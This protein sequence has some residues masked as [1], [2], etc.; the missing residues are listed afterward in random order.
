M[1]KK[2]NADVIA[3]LGCKKRVAPTIWKILGPKIDRYFEPFCGSAAIWLHRPEENKVGI[4]WLGDLD[5]LLVNA[6]RAIQHE[7][8]WLYENH[9]QIFDDFARLGCL[10]RLKD[11]DL[12]LLRQNLEEDQRWCDR[13]LALDFLQV[14]NT[15]MSA[16]INSSLN[17]N[18]YKTYSDR[19][20]ILRAG[21]KLDSVTVRVFCRDWE[22]LLRKSSLMDYESQEDSIRAVVLDPPYDGFEGVYDVQ[23]KGV[24]AKAFERAVEIASENIRVVYC[25]YRG[26]FPT[27]EG[28]LEIPWTQ[29]SKLGKTDP[30]TKGKEILLCSPHSDIPEEYLKF[31][32]SKGASEPDHGDS[33][34][35]PPSPA[36]DLSE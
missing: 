26:Q 6:L 27:P 33:S 25:C 35:A 16:S 2:F 31:T 11:R 23:S 15:T 8:Q 24:A 20:R 17:Q 21:K 14:V 9:L 7:S 28:W 12:D 22:Y 36:P 10:K 1:T 34:D 4:A 29:G 30:S 13:Q 3:R 18:S 32:V 19:S 5:G